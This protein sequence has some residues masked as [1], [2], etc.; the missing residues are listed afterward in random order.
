MGADAV[1]LIAR[2]LSQSLLE[3]LIEMADQANLDVLLEIHSES[4]VDKALQTKARLIG[5]N[6]RNLKS[7]STNIETTR[8]LAT[9]FPSDTVLV[10][11]S[12]IKT[13]KDIETLKQAGV[14][15]FLIGE[16]VVRADDATAFLKHLIT[17]RA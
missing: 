16:S 9:L 4:E 7:F 6:N 12:G 11:E 17:N 2:I 13:R 5:I 10:A 15:N 3:E 8:K 14:F 1:L